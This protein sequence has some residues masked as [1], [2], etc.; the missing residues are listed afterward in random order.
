[1]TL[2]LVR[3]LL[4]DVRRPCSW[5]RCCWGPFSSSGPRSRRASWASCRRSSPAGRPWRHDDRDIEEADL[6]G[7]GQDPP[8]H[9]RR[10]AHRAG[11]R[12]GHAVDRLRASADGDVSAS[13]PSAGPRAPSPARSTAARWNCCWPSRWPARASSSPTL[14]DLITIPP[15]PEP[16]G[17]QLARGLARLAHPD[18]GAEDQ[19]AGAGVLSSSSGPF[20]CSS[21]IGYR[22]EP[23]T[24]EEQAKRAAH[25]AGGFGPALW[26][27]GGLIFAVC[28]YTMWLSAAAVPLA[29]AGPGGVPDAGAVPGQRAGPDVGRQEALR[30]LTI[31]YYYQPQQVILGKPGRTVLPALAVLYGVGAVGYVVALGVFTRGDLPAPL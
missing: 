6:R 16:V 11:Q 3:K 30:P 14:L 7:A 21:P 10:R 2:T 18:R 27:V 1:M 4:R 13:G 28:G 8:H 20:E 17:R 23:E 22:P 12:H 19:T 9:H 15:V 5:W 26:L 25:R 29:R 31:F 24:P